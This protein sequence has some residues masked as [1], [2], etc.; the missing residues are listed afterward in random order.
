MGSPENKNA[1]ALPASAW[2][3]LIGVV[4]DLAS[5]AKEIGA[6]RCAS[7]SQEIDLSWNHPDQRHLHL[8]TTSCAVPNRTAH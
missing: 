7:H 8:L 5:D 3:I 4:W 6:Q 1:G 2:L